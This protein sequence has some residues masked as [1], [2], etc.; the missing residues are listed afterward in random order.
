MKKI[1]FASIIS[2]LFLFNNTNGMFKKSIKFFNKALQS[3]F[4]KLPSSV[5]KNQKS[6]QK[7][8]AFL[9]NPAHSNVPE[10]ENQTSHEYYLKAL[11]ETFSQKIENEISLKDHLEAQEKAFSQDNICNT[12]FKIF[13]PEKTSN[14]HHQMCDKCDLI[15][16]NDCI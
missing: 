11:E 13:N 3:N 2:F 1:I 7:S 15:I 10:T 16:G 14:P 9:K 4:S 5:F 12:C 8:F 6:L